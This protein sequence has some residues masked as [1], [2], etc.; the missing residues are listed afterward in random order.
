MPGWGSWE[1]V[2]A[3]VAE[4]LRE[5]CEATTFAFGS[6]P[7]ADIIVVV[8]HSPELN[9]LE[10]ACQSAAVIYCPVDY[11]ADPE[12]IASEAE[13]IKRYA[14]I[15]IHCESLR[16]FFASYAPV[17]YM[18]H[19]IRFVAP[20]RTRYRRRGPILWTGVR[21]NLQPL[22]DWLNKHPLPGELILLSNFENNTVPADARELGI[23]VQQP[24]RLELWT[25]ERHRALTA[26]ARAAIDIKGDDFRARHKPAAKAL[27]FVASGVPLAMNLDSSPVAHLRALGFETASPLNCERWLSRDYWRETVEFGRAMRVLLTRERIAA[28]YRW[29]F[30]CVLDERRKRAAVQEAGSQRYTWR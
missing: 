5:T 29:L 8:K 19:H 25:P 17:E 20:L 24:I 4:S 14:R 1:W 10:A 13:K 21:S 3:E 23:E 15:L 22:V 18:D 28:R 7:D 9:W 2:G 12:H 26:D 11:Y 30:T 6:V 16:P 27:D